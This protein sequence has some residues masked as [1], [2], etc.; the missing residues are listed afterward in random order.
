MFIKRSTNGRPSLPPRPNGLPPVGNLLSLDPDLHT[1]FATLAQNYGPILTLWLGKKI[2]IVPTV[3]FRWPARRRLRHSLDTVW[4]QVAHAEEATPPW[5]P[6]IASDA[7]NYVR[8]LITCTTELGRRR[9]DVSDCGTVKGEERKSL[10]AEFRQV[11]TEMTEL[12]GIP[13]MSDFYPGLARFELQGIKKKMKGLA[14]RF[15]RIFE[16]MID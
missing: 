11:V 7:G 5:T 10:G 12:L 14:E 2:G 4:T 6:C 8:L 15:D 3:T 1:Y 9:A 13:N 16:T